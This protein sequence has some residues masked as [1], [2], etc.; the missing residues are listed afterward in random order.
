M[1]KISNLIKVEGLKK[2]KIWL[3]Q[4]P[5]NKTYRYP[6]KISKIK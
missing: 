1:K 5:K 4:G 6:K 3:D 2:E